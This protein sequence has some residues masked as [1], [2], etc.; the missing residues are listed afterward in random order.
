MS[1]SI[2]MSKWCPSLCLLSIAPLNK[3][4]TRKM[5]QSTIKFIVVFSIVRFTIPG[6]IPLFI[7]VWEASATPLSLTILLTPSGVILERVLYTVPDRRGP[8]AAMETAKRVALFCRLTSA[9]WWTV[10]A[11]TPQFRS[12][13]RPVILLNIQGAPTSLTH[14]T[15]NVRD[16]SRPPEATHRP[17]ATAVIPCIQIE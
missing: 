8:A 2:A 9:V 10:L 4:V 11:S 16:A 17:L 13:R 5:L 15:I 12:L 6:F 14:L 1:F 7:E 3:K